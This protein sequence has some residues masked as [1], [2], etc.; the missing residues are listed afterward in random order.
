MSEIKTE[1]W[2]E[3]KFKK[4][5][6]ERQVITSR[7]YVKTLVPRIKALGERAG[8]RLEKY[9]EASYTTTSDAVD[10]GVEKTSRV[11]HDLYRLLIGDFRQEIYCCY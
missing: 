7:D 4:W 10:G 2:P 11:T 9:G 8:F 1:R 6:Q 5:Y 3:E